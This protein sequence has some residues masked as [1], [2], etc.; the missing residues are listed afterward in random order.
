MEHRI[1]PDVTLN[2]GHLIVNGDNASDF[3]TVAISLRNLSGVSVFLNGNGFL[4]GPDTV[5]S[6][7]VNPDKGDNNFVVLKPWCVK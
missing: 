4:F 7:E 6:I 2:N 3:N 5:S 1:T